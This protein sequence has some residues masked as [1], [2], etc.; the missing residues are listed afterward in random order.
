MC[1]YSSPLRLKT[2]GRREEISEIWRYDI[3]T[4][5]LAFRLHC[6]AQGN[7]SLWKNLPNLNRLMNLRIRLKQQ[8]SRIFHK[9]LC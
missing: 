1:L 4:P 9:L 7:L 6:A 5:K 3:I 8:Q 2:I